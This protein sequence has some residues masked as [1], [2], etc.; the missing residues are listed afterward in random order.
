MST[1]QG[2]AQL[3]GRKIT[4]ADGRTETLV[5]DLNAQVFLEEAFEDSFVPGVVN[6]I[7]NKYDARDM[8][9]VIQAGLLYKLPELSYEETRKMGFAIDIPARLSIMNAMT[10]AA[11]PEEKIR[12]I[13]D[14][15]QDTEVKRQ[16]DELEKAK[17]EGRPTGGSD[18]SDGKPKPTTAAESSQTSSG[19]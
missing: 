13:A 19:D 9:T 3:R 16:I 4:F 8:V 6:R 5:F 10:N 1:G 15:L 12:E 7:G 18:G 14:R 2:A 11:V 17:A